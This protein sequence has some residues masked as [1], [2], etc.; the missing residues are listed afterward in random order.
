MKKIHELIYWITVV[1]TLVLFGMA[2]LARNAI[3]FEQ[4]YEVV[5]NISSIFFGT[6]AL[7]FLLLLSTLPYPDSKS[8]KHL[9]KESE[10]F[11]ESSEDFSEEIVK[12]FVDMSKATNMPVDLLSGG[13]TFK[14]KDEPDYYVY[15][16]E[17]VIFLIFPTLEVYNPRTERYIGYNV[18]NVR[19]FS[20]MKNGKKITKNVATIVKQLEEMF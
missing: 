9:S 16:D 20:Y 8:R 4:E 1:F 18:N 10:D 13:W 7:V 15:N 17:G 11:S 5:F 2:L 3:L 19:Y 6:L 12:V 14:S